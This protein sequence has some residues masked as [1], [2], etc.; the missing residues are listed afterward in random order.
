MERELSIKLMRETFDNNYRLTHYLSRYLTYAPDCVKK[1][2][3]EGLTEGTDLSEQEAFAY[4][5]AAV[6]DLDMENSREDRQFFRRYLAPSVR[7]LDA[8]RYRNDPYFKTVHF[9]NTTIGRWDLKT[10]TYP[11]YRGFIASDPIMDE[12]YTEIQQ[13]GFF[14]EDFTFPAVME[15]GNEWMTLTPVDLDT[16]QTAINAAKGR[17]VTFGLGLGYYAFMVSEK[18]KVE[19]ITVVERSSDVISLFEQVLLPQFPHKEKVRIVCADAFAYAEGQLPKE[20]FNLAFVDIWRDASDGLEHY[21]HMKQYEHLCPK[22]KFLYWIEDT[23]LSRLR[24]HVFESGY[25]KTESGEVDPAALRLMLEKPSLR[26]LA[27][28]LTMDEI[29]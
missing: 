27:K 19:Q 1:E 22:T 17:V 15:D 26:A 6:F 29:I 3:I 23:I 13:L 10:V 20:S 14:S 12:T 21:L 2:M 25:A 18:E 8:A 4:L 7:C 24:A 5:L 9:P 11:A 16:C 28:T